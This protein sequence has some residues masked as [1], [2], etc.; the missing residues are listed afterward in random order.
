MA[1]LNRKLP[2]IEVDFQCFVDDASLQTYLATLTDDELVVVGT[3]YVHNAGAALDTTRIGGSNYANVASNLYPLGYVAVGVPGATPGTAY[4]SYYTSSDQNFPAGATNPHFTGTLNYDLNGNYTFVPGESR[5]FTITPV[6]N[7]GTSTI[8]IGNNQYVSPGGGATTGGFW[9]LA[10]DRVSL[11]PVSSD[12][13]S[14]C[15]SDVSSP[16]PCGEFFYTGYGSGVA[17]SEIERLATA[18]NAVTARQIA[19]LTSQGPAIGS[20][21]MV[22][23]DLAWAFSHLGGTYY[24][25]EKLAPIQ[26]TFT[27]VANGPDP[28]ELDANGGRTSTFAKGV[29][30]ATNLFAQQDQSGILSGIFARDGTGLYFAMLGAQQS[31]TDGPA[32]IV[33]FSFHALSTEPNGDWPMTDTPG[34][35][36]AYHSI[37]NDYLSAYPLS[38][39]GIYAW[40]LRYHYPS[41]TDAVESNSAYFDGACPDVSS[42]SFTSSEYCDVWNQLK[43]EIGSL[44]RVRKLFGDGNDGMRS[45]IGSLTS[46]AITASYTVLNNQFAV[47]PGTRVKISKS[48]WLKFGSGIAALGGVIP[49]IGPVF[50]LFSAVLNIGSTASAVATPTPQSL[51]RYETVFDTTMG[52]AASM[53]DTWQNNSI[54][55]YDVS[56]NMVYT[57]FNKL[58]TVGAKIADTSSGW[59]FSGAVSEDSISEALSNGA[60]RSLYL[61]LLPQFY[62]ID[63]VMT[64]PVDSLSLVGSINSWDQKC[65]VTYPANIDPFSYVQYPG[66]GQSGTPD[67]GLPHS[68][69]RHQRQPESFDAGVAAELR[70]PQHAV[71]GSRQPG[72][73]LPQLPA[74]R[75]LLQ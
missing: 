59:Q 13:S 24:T 65:D 56:L 68:R 35:I 19:V 45:V 43:S 71:R 57:D 17:A 53:L 8:T 5:T 1:V 72:S 31:P 2:T 41:L 67:N 11:Y 22:T 20:A 58:D 75:H 37:S 54:V 40:D 18:L 47:E 48:N 6:A 73:R 50:G 30:E 32:D 70:P 62:S 14:P 16:T 44:V 12:P 69:G 36:A 15:V 7:P 23:G 29:L 4:E 3:T 66:I 34:H 26:S 60:T 64:A 10:L 39:T 38:M 52:E 61:Q 51:P 25:L 55:A 33:D 21:D 49:G 46:D 28:T 74:G 63:A 27:L 9:L 42:E